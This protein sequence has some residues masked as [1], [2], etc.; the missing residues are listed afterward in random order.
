M[1]SQTPPWFRPLMET[2]ERVGYA[3]RDSDRN[4]EGEDRNGLRAEHESAGPQDI[5]QPT[6]SPTPDSHSQDHP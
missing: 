2:F 6:A 5:A 3:R 4:P 1:T